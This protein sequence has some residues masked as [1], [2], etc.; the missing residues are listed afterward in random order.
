MAESVVRS[1]ELLT[2]V[3][4]FQDGLPHDI[5][6]VRPAADAAATAMRFY[7][8][9]GRNYYSLFGATPFFALVDSLHSCVGA[10]MV[11]RGDADVPRLLRF[12]P[13]AL[14]AVLVHATLDG[15]MV[16]L[17][18]H[19]YRI[20]NPIGRDIAKLLYATA[21]W[22]HRP[23][24]LVRLDPHVAPDLP[25]CVADGAA[26]RGD[27]EALKLLV[28]RNAPV[29]AP[30]TY[31][32]LQGHLVVL[33]YLHAHNIG[34]CQKA[35]MDGAAARGHLAVVQFLHAH[36]REGCGTR[37]IDD[38]AANGHADVVRFLVEHRDE[39]WTRRGIENAKFNGE[40]E[41]ARYLEGRSLR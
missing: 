25:L 1:H 6:R 28:G 41:I 14:P 37:A 4:E 11:D 10:W 18:A 32:A 19:L 22:F 8:D 35:A 31:A 13:S 12:L 26:Y 40:V 36:R 15:N 34:R 33:E 23:V 16:L 24:V 27:L 20:E 9:H 30:M 5:R 39:G 2:L 7:F 17:N 29:N 21:A 3:C 38:A